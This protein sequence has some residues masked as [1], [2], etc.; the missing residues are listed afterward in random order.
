MDRMIEKARKLLKDS[1]VEQIG[2]EVWNVIG[3]HGTYTVAMDHKGKIACNCPGFQSKGR[4]SHLA[5]III[6]TKIPR[7]TLAYDSRRLSF[8]D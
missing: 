5:A 7:E 8:T 6:L 1:R 4:C 3:D 2:D